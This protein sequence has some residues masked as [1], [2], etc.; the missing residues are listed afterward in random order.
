VGWLLAPL[1]CWLAPRI[2]TWWA[3]RQR[4]YGYATARG[5]PE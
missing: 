3:R 1:A 5:A 2:D 4:S